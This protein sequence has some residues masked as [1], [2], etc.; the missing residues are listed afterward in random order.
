MGIVGVLA[1]NRNNHGGVKIFAWYDL[2]PGR[3]PAFCGA[4]G[5]FARHLD[6]VN[7]SS[8]FALVGDFYG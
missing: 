5:A 3:N 7:V 4:T 8:V 1:G 6:S 2:S